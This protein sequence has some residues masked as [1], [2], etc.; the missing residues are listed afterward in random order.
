[1]SEIFK[2]FE[3][4]WISVICYLVIIVEFVLAFLY[5]RRKD[6]RLVDSFKVNEKIGTKYDGQ[7]NKGSP[8]RPAS[9]ICNTTGDKKTNHKTNKYPVKTTSAFIHGKAI[10]KKSNSHV[11]QK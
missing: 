8:V 3:L 5:A 11:N 1:M 4:T 2:Y 10:I 9:E 7:K 6:R